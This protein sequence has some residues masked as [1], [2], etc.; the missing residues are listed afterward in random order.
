MIIL[1][2]KRK[3]SVLQ[4]LMLI[5]SAVLM[6]WAISAEDGVYRMAAAA[7]SMSVMVADAVS[8]ALMTD[9][10]FP[11][12]ISVLIVIAAVLMASAI[13]LDSIVPPSPEPEIVEEEPPA[14]TEEEDLIEEE[15]DKPE[16]PKV[17]SAPSVSVRSQD[18]DSGEPEVISGKGSG[19]VPSKPEAFNLIWFEDESI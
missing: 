18:V 6:Y 12:F 3:P 15:E 4:I 14:A 13:C 16:P 10:G 1:S 9:D 7:V 19:S 11:K 5:A 2:M 8:F 17:P